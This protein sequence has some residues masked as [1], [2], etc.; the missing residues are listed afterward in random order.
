LVPKL[1][2]ATAYVLYAKDWSQPQV[3][4]LWVADTLLQARVPWDEL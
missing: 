3:P 1:E 2:E 4:E